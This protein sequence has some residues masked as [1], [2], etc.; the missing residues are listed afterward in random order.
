MKMRNK[1]FNSRSSL[2]GAPGL[3]ADHVWRCV[4]HCLHV[5]VWSC[6]PSGAVLLHCRMLGVCGYI[7]EVLCA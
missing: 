6:H 1:V 2:S 5:P 7:D 4:Y 3:C